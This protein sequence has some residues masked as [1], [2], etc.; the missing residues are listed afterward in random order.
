[1]KSP[2]RW[3]SLRAL[4]IASLCV[5]LSALGCARSRPPQTDAVLLAEGNARIEQMK[6]D[7]QV[8]GRA[9]VMRML[10]SE[11]DDRTVDLLI[12]SGGGDFGAFGAAFLRGWNEVEGD[13]AMPVFDAVTGVSAGA[14]I[15]P[16]AFLG[17]PED[18]LACENLYRNPQPDLVRTRGPLFF[19]PDNESF[20][21]VPGLERVMR[22]EID[23][24]RIRRIAEQGELGRALFVNTTDLDLGCLHPFELTS[25]AKLAGENG[26]YERVYQI[27]LASSGIP[28][29]FPSREIDGVLYVDGCI[30]ANILHGGVTKR[31]QTP[32][33]RFRQA[34]PDEPPMKMRYWVV[35]N[36]QQ[37]SQPC[38][39]QPTWPDVLARSVDVSVR[40]STITS[41]R[42]LYAHAEVSNL[43]G[44][45]EIEVR[46]I[47]IPN[48]W[49]APVEGI[50][51]KETMNSL[52]D[53]GYQLGKSRAAWNTEAP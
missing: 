30:T 39:T 51:K 12:I 35:L 25:A 16:F 2:T 45:G 19:M 14:L 42:H 31:E 26:D 38:V 32:L 1:M 24:E 13:G 41:L 17:A 20:A 43:L 34:M 44:D 49:R 50:F 23:V 22:T 46:W 21:E 10:N 36:N 53:I 5:T 18:L 47:G 37:R 40:A 11:G 28:G 48:D 4:T 6:A 8:T 29:V 15:A 27:L 9:L 7:A 52:A 3:N 33:Y